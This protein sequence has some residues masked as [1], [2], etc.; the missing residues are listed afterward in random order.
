MSAESTPKKKT[1]W[2]FK[3]LPPDQLHPLTFLRPDVVLHVHDLWTSGRHNE[4]TYRTFSLPDVTNFRPF[5]MMGGSACL[6]YIESWC[7]TPEDVGRLRGL[8]SLAELPA[9][10][11]NYLT[12]I[13]HFTGSIKALPDGQLI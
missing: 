2:Q 5:H 4:G 10:F 11:W 7:I 13:P 1:P 6:D 12:S 8:E 3:P 9:A